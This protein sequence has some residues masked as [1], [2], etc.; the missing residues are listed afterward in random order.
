MK[1]NKLTIT[2]RQKILSIYFSAG[3]PNLNDTVQIISGFRKNG[4][5]M[6]EIGLPFSDP[7]DGPT[8][9]S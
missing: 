4:V 5:D 8:I 9:T 2:G 7:L 1:Q 3:Y 6:I